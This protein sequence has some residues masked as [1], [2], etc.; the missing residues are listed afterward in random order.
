MLWDHTKYSLFSFIQTNIGDNM[1]KL[2][3]SAT[4]VLTISGLS[5]SG[6]QTT[7]N[8][9]ATTHTAS[10]SCSVKVGVLLVM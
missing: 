7:R 5:A 8:G 9:V 3:N 2:Y 1:Q 4:G 10:G 6:S